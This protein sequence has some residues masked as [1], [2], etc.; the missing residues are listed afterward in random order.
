MRGEP[1]MATRNKEKPMT[2]REYAMQMLK[3]ARIQAFGI[4]LVAII[5]SIY[6]GAWLATLNHIIHP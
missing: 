1:F 5:L 4:M 6:V 3:A 2:G